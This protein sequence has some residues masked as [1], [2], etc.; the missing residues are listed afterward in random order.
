MS[1]FAQHFRD[2]GWGMIPTMVLGILT[3]SVA[4]RYAMARSRRLLPLLMSLG[5][6]TVATGGLG[7][8]SRLITTCGAVEQGPF[9][10]GQDV[11]VMIIGFGEAL[12]DVAFALVF[13]VLAAAC[14][15]CGALRHPRQGKPGEHGV[16]AP[17]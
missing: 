15:S 10:A 9:A 2:G 1:H 13:V 4:V 17:V 3:L 8:V 14:A 12:N 7:F 11:R 6:L 5:V 16:P